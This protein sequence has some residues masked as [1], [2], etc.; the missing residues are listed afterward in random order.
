MRNLKAENQQLKVKVR[1]L[2]INLSA[3]QRQIHFGKLS[4]KKKNEEVS[5]LKKEID[6]LKN[7]IKKLRKNEK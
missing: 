1:N 7:E 2:R 3:L 5:T 4:D 6:K